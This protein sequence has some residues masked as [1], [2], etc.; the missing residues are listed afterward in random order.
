MKTPNSTKVAVGE[1][2]GVSEVITPKLGSLYDDAGMSGIMT[3]SRLKRLSARDNKGVCGS[4]GTLY[5]TSDSSS[6]LRHALLR[7][8]EDLP[9]TASLESTPPS[10]KK[11]QKNALL[12]A[13]SV[14]PSDNDAIIHDCQSL[15]KERS[16]KSDNDDEQDCT[17]APKSVSVALY[18][19]PETESPFVTVTVSGLCNNIKAA[20]MIHDSK[21][22][23]SEV[24]DTHFK[25]NSSLLASNDD[26]EQSPK[27]SKKERKAIKSIK[28]S[29]PSLNKNDWTVT[30]VSEHVTECGNESDVVKFPQES[31]EGPL[32]STELL[33]SPSSSSTND[34]LS[35][36]N[37]QKE[38]KIKKSRKSKLSSPNK[39]GSAVLTTQEHVTELEYEMCK[40]KSPQ[41]FNTS[42]NMWNPAV[43]ISPLAAEL[44]E[45][46]KSGSVR[47]EE[48]PLKSSTDLESD[49]KSEV[50]TPLSGLE[51]LDHPLMPSNKGEPSPDYSATE[52]KAKKSRKRNSSL[53]D[54]NEGIVTTVS[55]HITAFENEIGAVK[56]YQ[57]SDKCSLKSTEP[58]DGP[59]L[60][61]NGDE[62]SPSNSH[63]ESKLKNSR[64]SKSSPPSKNEWTISKVPEGTT[65]LGNEKSEVKPPQKFDKCKNGENPIMTISQ[66]PAEIEECPKSVVF[67]GERKTQLKNLS[68]T[69]SALANKACEVNDTSDGDSETRQVESNHNVKSSPILKSKMTKE[70]RSESSESDSDAESRKAI[71]ESAQRRIIQTI[72]TSESESKKYVRPRTM[73]TGSDTSDSVPEAMSFS[74]GRQLIMESLKN[75]ADSI[76]REKHRRKEKRKERLEKYKQQKEEKLIRLK[77]KRASQEDA[78]CSSSEE[79]GYEE[80]DVPSVL[81]K[82]NRKGGVKWKKENLDDSC[83]SKGKRFHSDD[84]AEP[85]RMKDKKR[86]N[87]QKDPSQHCGNLRKLPDDV[88]ENLPDQVPLKLQKTDSEVTAEGKRSHEKHIE[89]KRQEYKKQSDIDYIP[90]STCGAT[91]FG[92]M[93]LDK[94]M[95]APKSM[96]ERAAEFRQNMLFGTRIR[97]GPANAQAIYQHKLKASG[98]GRYFR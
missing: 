49:T 9:G 62:S 30:A 53:L 27:Y 21:K 2:C 91:E 18:N 37:S 65:E 88:L 48:T 64:K 55:E 61:S 46:L 76:Q 83:Q 17:N 72:S 92:V 80:V 29:R 16:L 32:R 42:N 26:D 44:E 20:I 40:V 51:P 70:V 45:H 35:P 71:M 77:E 5:G 54:G 25:V 24:Y 38:R 79:S 50:N 39:N 98:K 78:S 86:K 87:E 14:T 43:C 4:I 31:D 60:T 68:D 22:G 58:R 84:E 82:S 73:S 11:L 36:N 34:E 75:V 95:R 59:S 33:N 28:K 90:L 1:K 97:R 12:E 15:R 8:F 3:R 6:N 56:S 57:G 96:A 41:K 52:R 47:C 94:F 7:C 19:A 67:I 81:E 89:N 93:P 74:A 85:E 23:G 63:K 13:G 69:E 66:L 10:N